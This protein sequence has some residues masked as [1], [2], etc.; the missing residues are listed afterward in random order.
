MSEQNDKFK[1]LEKFHP[2]FKEKLLELIEGEITKEKD[3]FRSEL[4]S[5][6]TNN[7]IFDFKI[8]AD[9]YDGSISIEP[10]MTLQGFYFNNTRGGLRISIQLETDAEQKVIHPKLK[11]EKL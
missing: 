8:E 6:F 3:R 9:N 2:D 4:I 10:Y 5:D 7:L 11:I 1:I